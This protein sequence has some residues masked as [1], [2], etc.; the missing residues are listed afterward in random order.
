ML[1]LNL[2]RRE[3]KKPF[4]LLAV[5][6]QLWRVNCFVPKSRRKMNQRA[7]IKSSLPLDIDKIRGFA[8]FELYQGNRMS[9][10]ILQGEP[11]AEKWE[12][13]EVCYTCPEVP[14]ETLQL[15]SAEMNVVL[16]S[17]LEVLFLFGIAV[18]DHQML[19]ILHGDL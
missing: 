7:A 9:A 18:E 8:E 5:M 19:Q 11:P 13:Q 16:M 2:Q 14:S 17:E 4:F 1:Q 12:D 15:H 6:D 10:Q 3:S